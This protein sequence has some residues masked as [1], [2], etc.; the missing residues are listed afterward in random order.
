[1]HATRKA[2]KEE[3]GQ[4][5]GLALLIAL[6]AVSLFSVIGLHLALVATAQ[7]KISDNY[8][9]YIQARAA[10]LAGLNHARVLLRGLGFDDQLR[11]PDGTYDVSPGYVAYARSHGYRSPV[12]WS[13]ARMLDLQ[14][15][16]AALAAIPDDGVANAG[17]HPGGD[18]VELIHRLGIVRTVPNP[19]GPGILCASGYFVKVSDNNGEASE[20]ARDPEDNPFT[21]GDGQI[22]VRSMGIAQTIMEGTQAGVRRNSVVLFE[23]RLKRLSTFD[24]DAPLVVLSD[25]VAPS[26]SGMF[27]GIQ[28]SVQG[29]AANPGIATIDPATGNGI[30]PAV[31][32][33]AGLSPAQLGNIQGTGLAPSIQDITA[34]IAA[35]ADKNLLL[36]AA[37]LW[38]FVRQDAPRFADN[39][40]S[41]PQRWMDAAPI[42]LGRYD[43]LLPPGAPV[44]DPKVTYV[45]GDL[46]VDG[47]LEGAG[48]LIVTGRVLLRGNLVFHGTV[49][50]IGAGELDCGGA[51]RITGAVFLAN[52]SDSNETLIRGTARL[53]VREISSIVF[54]R[55]TIRMA[56]SLIPAVQLSFREVTSIIDP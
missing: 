23:A 55:E 15:P 6:I 14:N 54:D 2:E 8:E 19:H 53:T 32:I 48:L 10:A 52:L 33:A 56:A 21:D 22:I 40:C 27:G 50:I 44:Q 45:D 31:Q 5:H 35:H 41:G 13:I 42:P 3:P 30:A 38:R 43:P 37:Y 20:Q 26:S 11:G 36:D 9:S 29:G 1:M 49:L 24:L 28:F 16:A 51:S 39:L 34:T 17:R 18:G 25:T 7:V 47:N 46:V 4:Q 12:N